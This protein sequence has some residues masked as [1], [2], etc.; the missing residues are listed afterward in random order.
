MYCRP[1]CEILFVHFVNLFRLSYFHCI[2]NYLFS[3]GSYLTDL[4]LWSSGSLPYLP[5]NLGIETRRNLA[6]NVIL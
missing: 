2:H 3:T 4:L 6:I 5:I 1:F